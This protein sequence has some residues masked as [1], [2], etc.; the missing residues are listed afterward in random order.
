MGVEHIGAYSARRPGPL[1]SRAFGTLP[2]R[3]GQELA[4]AGITSI[5]EANAFMRRGLSLPA[6]TMTFP[7]GLSAVR[8][9]PGTAGCSGRSRAWTA[10]ALTGGM[11]AGCRSQAQEGQPKV[12]K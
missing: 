1:R 10:S 2:G 6:H 3:A 8:E 5:D 11:I 9:Q 4:L 12:S 7:H